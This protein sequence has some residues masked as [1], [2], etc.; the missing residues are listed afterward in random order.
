MELELAGKV[1]VVSAG[2]KG[3]GRECALA[4]AREG[5]RVALFSRDQR[6]LAQVSEEIAQATGQ[7]PFTQTAD[8]TDAPSIAAF[9]EEVRNRLGPVQILVANS[10]GPKPGR[11]EQ[12]ADEAWLAA[13]NAA[14][15]STVR[16]VRAAIPHMLQSGAGAVVAIQS[17]SVKQPIHDMVLSNGVR[18]GVAGLMKSLAHEYGPQGLRFNVVCPGRVMTDR[19]VAV[20]TSHGGSLEERIAKMAAEVPLRRLGRP[21]EV[22]DAVLFLCSNRASYITGSVLSVDGGNVRS[23]Y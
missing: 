11:F 21:S 1:A 2:S 8:L 5:A 22:A 4:L 17:T 6:N 10:A 16:L 3:M 9:F 12:H 19:F 23:L 20:E 13:F 7:A 15:L 14:V 18:P